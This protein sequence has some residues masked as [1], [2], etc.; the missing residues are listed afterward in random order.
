MGI[1]GGVHLGEDED[2]AAGAAGDA[3]SVVEVG[4]DEPCLR[5]ALLDGQRRL[6]RQLAEQVLRDGDALRGDALEGL[7]DRAGGAE[8]HSLSEEFDLGGE[9]DVLEE[10]RGR[11]QERWARSAG[12]ECKGRGEERCQG[13]RQGKGKEG[14]GRQCR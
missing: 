13:G 11:G 2:G 4:G 3:E 6:P 1:G 9:I 7:E 8:V 5:S 10:L 14:R 12:T